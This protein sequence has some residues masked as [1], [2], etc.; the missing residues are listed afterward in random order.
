MRVSRVIDGGGDVQVDYGTTPEE[1]QLHF[2]GCGTVNRVTILTD[3]LG[4]AKV[5]C[6]DNLLFSYGTDR[7]QGMH[8][9]CKC[10]LQPRA[11]NMRKL[12]RKASM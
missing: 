6:L 5:R 8:Q 9:A 7:L 10:G 4:N 2:N 3:K 1:L 11:G 12:P